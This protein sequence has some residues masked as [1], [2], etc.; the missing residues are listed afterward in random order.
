MAGPARAAASATPWRE[1]AKEPGALSWKPVAADAARKR[2]MIDE[3]CILT[4]CLN[5]QVKL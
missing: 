4:V 5:A 1:S 2:L 3:A